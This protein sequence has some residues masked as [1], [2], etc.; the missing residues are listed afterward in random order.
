VS[1]FPSIISSCSYT[2]NINNKEYKQHNN[3][4][5]YV[6][7]LTNEMDKKEYY[8]TKLWLIYL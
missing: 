7:R 6:E 5:K 8:S 4:T 2:I 3:Q 1:Y